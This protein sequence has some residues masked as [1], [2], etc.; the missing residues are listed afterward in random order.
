VLTDGRFIDAQGFRLLEDD[1]VAVFKGESD[2]ELQERDGVVR[3]SLRW[4]QEQK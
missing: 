3:V 4:S 1:T 2:D